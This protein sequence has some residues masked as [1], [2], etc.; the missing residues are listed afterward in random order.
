MGWGGKV[1]DMYI[2]KTWTMGKQMYFIKI[3]NSLDVLWKT[4]SQMS[5]TKSVMML[6]SK[7]EFAAERPSG[8]I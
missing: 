3:T 5:A 6:M 7:F 2:T 8:L 1:E 4:N